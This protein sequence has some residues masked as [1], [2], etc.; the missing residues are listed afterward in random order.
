MEAKKIL[1]ADDEPHLVRSLVFVLEKAGFT[2]TTAANGEEALQKT[3]DFLPRLIFLD[4]MMPKKNG[5]EVC[6]EIKA[7]PALNNIYIIILTAKGQEADRDE[8]VKAGADEFITKPF[9]PLQLV[10]R[11]KTLLA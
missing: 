7:D 5:Y 8:G 6:A 2:V 9:S 4:V 1:V 3:R 11:V 10:E